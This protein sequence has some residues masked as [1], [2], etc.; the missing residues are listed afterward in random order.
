MPTVTLIWMADDTLNF[1]IETITFALS[2]EKVVDFIRNNELWA[3][4]DVEKICR[5]REKILVLLDNK[6]KDLDFLPQNKLVFAFQKNI[7]KSLKFQPYKEWFEFAEAT[8][9]R[10]NTKKDFEKFEKNKTGA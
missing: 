5:V 10:Q 6:S 1:D 4:K 8:Q 3:T 7:V 2:P 9:N